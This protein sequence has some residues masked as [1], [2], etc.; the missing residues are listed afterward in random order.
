MKW[1]DDIKSYSR[2]MHSQFGRHQWENPKYPWASW[3]LKDLSRSIPLSNIQETGSSYTVQVELPGVK[4]DQIKVTY[5]KEH[6]VVSANCE[7]DSPATPT[8]SDATSTSTNAKEDWATKRSYHKKF[9]FSEPIVFT[10]IT[11]KLEDGI[12]TLTVPK[13]QTDHTVNIL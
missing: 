8:N 7:E 12:L 5:S 4:K 9:Y 10:N 1:K 6:L 3:L 13:E 11:A 2:D